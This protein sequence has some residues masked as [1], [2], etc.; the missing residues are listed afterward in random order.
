M[1]QKLPILRYL[2]S[3]AEQTGLN[4]TLNIGLG[5]HLLSYCMYTCKQQRRTRLHIC[6]GSSESLLLA[7]G[8]NTEISLLVC[9]FK[10]QSGQSTAMVMSRWS[11]NLTSDHDCTGSCDVI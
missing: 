5:L 10:S 3:V 7:A 4:L 1:T 6:T 8:I 2:V 11:V 9:G